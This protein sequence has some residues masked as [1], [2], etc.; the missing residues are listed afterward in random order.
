MDLVQRKKQRIEGPEDS[1][2]PSG[3]MVPRSAM[4]VEVV[5]VEAE[6]DAVSPSQA[7]PTRTEFPSPLRIV[8]K[9][10]SGGQGMDPLGTG[11]PPL[12]I[13]PKIHE[14]TSNEE[15]QELVC[16]CEARVLE[17][18]ETRR[19]ISEYFTEVA[20]SG[21]NDKASRED[22]EP[23]FQVRVGE[24][25]V[26]LLTKLAQGMLRGLCDIPLRNLARTGTDNEISLSSVARLSSL[27]VSYS[28]VTLFFL[29]IFVCLG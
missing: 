4:P 3:S 2:L 9:L 15:Y 10:K 19:A 24:R 26:P 27:R 7:P 20:P 14:D 21:E 25:V 12:V 17:G 23:F 22:L 6:P 16:H 28:K 8:A 5:D 13:F 11:A 1:A 18:K 29:T